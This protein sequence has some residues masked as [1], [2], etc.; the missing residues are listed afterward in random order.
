MAAPK[1]LSLDTHRFIELWA[2]AKQ[3]G[4]SWKDFVQSIIDDD[5]K[6]GI[7]KDHA[8][9]FSGPKGTKVFAD[10]WKRYQAWCI[11]QGEP[12]PQDADA[13]SYKQDV[14]FF[15]VSEAALAKC[16]ALRSNKDFGKAIRPDGWRNRIGKMKGGGRE[17]ADWTS[18]R[19][20]L[21]GFF[22]K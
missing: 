18:R 5:G 8:L 11:N 6:T 13:S 15:V 4:R 2:E 17:A 3:K 1:I 10:Y 7:A 9:Y 21:A 20:M 22:E 19:N 12:L 16:N 14:C